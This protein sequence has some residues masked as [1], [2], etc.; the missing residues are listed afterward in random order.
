MKARPLKALQE[1]VKKEKNRYFK[2]VNDK[3]RKH[4]KINIELPKRATEHSVAYDIYSPIDIV[5]EPHKS[6]VIWTDIKAK[7]NTNE[8]LLINVRSSM[9]KYPVMLANS[10]GWIE[11]DY[12]EN[13]NN[14]GNIG[15]NLYN[16]S[17]IDYIVKKGDRIA[18]A[19]FINYL[20]A[21][22]GNTKNKRVGGFGST[23]VN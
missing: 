23:E 16:L 11:A 3:F 17:D 18:Q 10:Q 19:M 1:E 9:G 22:S 5:V 4:K 8:A 6:V 7:F 14:D 2:L 13:P 15:V 20:V 12:Y 21:D